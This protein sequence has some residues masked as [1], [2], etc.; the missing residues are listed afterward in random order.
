MTSA[1]RERDRSELLIPGE[2]AACLFDLDGVLTRTAEL[3]AAAWKQTFDA[4]LRESAPGEEPFDDVVDYDSYVDGRP[5]ADGVRAFLASR[6]MELPEGSPSDPPSL[7]T[8]QG[9]AAR[10]NQLVLHLIERRGVVP[11]PGSL[12]FLSAVCAAGLARA[13][14]TSSENAGVVL[15]AAGLQGVFDVQVDGRVARDLGLP[16]KPAPDVFLEA[17]RRLAVAPAGA[18]VFEDALAGV[19]AARAGAFGFVVGI[20]HY[21][22]TVELKD[23]GADV[24][25]SDLAELLGS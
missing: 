5:R 21:G 2:I 4:F 3:H 24:V 20:D 18:A 13:V 14:V 16:G 1:E 22:Q 11:Y 9:L 12:R 19:R 7:D 15:R 10:K 25:V 23:S 6:G 8:V 17:A